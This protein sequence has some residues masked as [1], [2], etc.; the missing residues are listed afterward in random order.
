[1]ADGQS[2][3][4]LA[5]LLRSVPATLPEDEASSDCGGYLIQA[6]AFYGWPEHLASVHLNFRD[7]ARQAGIDNVDMARLD[8]YV[9]LVDFSHFLELAADAAGDELLALRWAASVNDL[10]L[11][12]YLLCLAYA[13][14][15][16]VA[17]N[18][19]VQFLSIH[20]D[21]ATCSL[22]EEGGAATLAWTYSPVLLRQDQLIDR[23]AA[24]CIGRMRALLPAHNPPQRVELQR[25][26]PA[27]VSLHHGLLGP[28]VRFGCERNAFTYGA[29]LL[30]VPNP[31]SDPNLFSALCEL[32]ARLLGE[33]RCQRDL[34][35][36]VKEEMLRR[37]ADGDVALESI[38]RELGHSSRGLQR[39]LA[40]HGT[41]FNQLLE[42]TR[43]EAAR[44]YI[45][46]TDFL[47]SEIAYRLGFSTIGNFTRAAKRWFGCTPRE[48]RQGLHSRR[49][50]G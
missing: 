40:A 46:E 47:I 37:L 10:A 6:R 49:K 7:I 12:P 29:D 13:P 43:R 15:L 11:G 32:N 16:R 23:G 33:R 17:L 8:S 41:T 20:H 38:A 35:L 50:R 30:D 26:R 2:A 9:N 28:N 27:S 39:R 44:Q 14:T 18:A 21:G 5:G 19:I 48:Y 25:R 3:D 34:V 36:R 22:R 1:M 42:I 31:N 4:L 24:L 45:E